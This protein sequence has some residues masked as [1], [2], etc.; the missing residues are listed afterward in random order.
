[1]DKITTHFDSLSDNHQVVGELLDYREYYLIYKNIIFKIII[2]H[3]EKGITIKSNNYV[4]SFN[5]IDLSSLIKKKLS[6]TDEAY[7]FIINLF[8]ANQVEIKNIIANKEMRL[9]SK[10]TEKNEEKEIV[11]NMKYNPKNKDF[12][13]VELNNR[14]NKIKKKFDDLEKENKKLNDEIHL[15]KTHFNK[16]NP[17]D[18][19]IISELTKEAYSDDISDNTFAVF[20]SSQDIFYLIYATKKKSIVGFDLIQQKKIIEIVNSHNEYISNFRYYFDKTNKRDLIISISYADKNLKLWDALS[21]ECLTSISNIYVNGYL[22]SACFLKEDNNIYILTSNSNLYG[23]SGPIKV[24]DFNGNKIKEIA[25]S[26]ENTSFIDIFFDKKTLKTFVL[27]G[28]SNYVKS[29]DYANNELFK[30]Y[31]DNY[32]NNHLSIIISYTETEVKL[33]ESCYDSNIRVWDFYS[34]LLLNKIKIG[35]NWLYGICL[36]NSKY[37]FVGC[38]DKTIKLIDLR[39]A[40]IVKNFRGHNNSVLTIKKINHPQFGECL[41]TQGYDADQIK[42]WSNKV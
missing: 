42:L 23:D 10:I 12:D 11:I 38:S 26:N 32:N 35:D 19:H 4:I 25:D 36:W 20:K 6:S 40:Y 5:E 34:G 1:M 24:F 27:T 29:Y 16:E 22:Y 21:W 9:L 31:S 30:K 41:I 14:Y 37:L 17:K 15:L 39:E 7:Q 33:I 28:N 3:K 13:F 2:A 8:E 18:V